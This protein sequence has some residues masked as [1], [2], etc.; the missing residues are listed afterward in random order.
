MNILETASLGIE[1]GSTKIKGVLLSSDNQ[2]IAS[3]GYSWENKLINNI[4]TYDYSEIIYGLQQCY[5][6]IKKQIKEKYNLTINK[7]G[8]IGISA[9][10]H[11]YIVIDKNNKPL[12][13]F[14]TWRNTITEEASNELS[15][16]FNFHIPQR[17]SIAH[18][19]QAILN[20]EN[21]LKDISFLATLAV[22]IH[23][24][25]TN[26][27]I[28]GVGEASGMFPIDNS[29][30]NY[31]EIMVN[32]FDVLLKA[33]NLP[34]S[35]K[36]ILPEVKIAG[37]SAGLL[38]KSGALLLDPEGD[39]QSDIPFCPPEGDAGT[40]MVATNAIKPTTGNV[41]AGTSIFSMLV[42]DKPLSKR[43][44]EIDIVTTPLG[45]P[46][47]M[48]HCNNCSTDINNFINLFSQYNKLMGLNI[49]RDFL[50]DKLFKTALDGDS[51]AGGLSSVNYYSGEHIT[52]FNSGLPFLIHSANS[53]F[54]L[55]NL[56]RSLISSAYTTLKYGFNIL[57]KEDV[58]VESIIG[59][60]GIFK[61]EKVGQL[62]L[63]AALDVPVTVMEHADVGGAWGM[64]VLAKF[65]LI[66]EKS[67]IEYLDT[68]IFKDTIKKTLKASKK[69]IAGFNKY[70]KRFLKSLKVEKVAI[71]NIGE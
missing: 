42:L 1:F 5:K 15:N 12:T 36:S 45:A 58:K 31:D 71:K 20:K 11:G 37:E 40:G 14:R 50:Y 64:A 60:G 49:D 46:V 8:A 62:L 44:N 52:S 35:L 23:Y 66:K 63:S 2:V 61:V 17:W 13:E 7:L 51:D 55:S 41:S 19:Y 3:A 38:S 47:A 16:L 29:I 21:H 26:K 4:W 6:G 48:V 30:N 10:M 59:H 43:Y 24:L 56:M 57:K 54:T 34:Y 25:L 69:D 67:L 39:L 28:V 65:I 70:Y 53:N 32:K 18:L 33:N 22:Y 68:I 27:K 9:M